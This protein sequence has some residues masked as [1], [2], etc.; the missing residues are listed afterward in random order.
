M[1]NKFINNFSHD[2]LN[3]NNKVGKIRKN[4]KVNSFV[5]SR[6]SQ[7]YIGEIQMI[8]HSQIN[9]AIYQQ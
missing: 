5:K 6:D 3:T 2:T 9:K 8:Y 1:I 7:F 4:K